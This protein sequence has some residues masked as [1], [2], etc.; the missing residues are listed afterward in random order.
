[1]LTQPPVVDPTV[2]DLMEMVID[3]ETVTPTQDP[4]NTISPGEH[5]MAYCN[6][7]LLKK[8]LQNTCVRWTF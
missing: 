2:I 6:K 7:V 5:T 3:L 8:L 1:V 4:Q